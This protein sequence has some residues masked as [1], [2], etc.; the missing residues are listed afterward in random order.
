MIG[1]TLSHYKVLSK[2]GAGG[3]GDV[4]LAEDTELGRKVALKVLPEAMANSPERLERFRR[5]ARAVAALDHPNIVRIHNFEEAAGLKLLVMELVD[6]ESLDRI[7][8]PGGMPLAKVFSIAVPMADALAAAHEKGIT[9]RD[10]KPANVMLTAGGTVKVLDFG[11]AK[12][13]TEETAA[14]EEDDETALA[15][16][17]ADL[18][19]EGVVMGTAPYMSPEQLQGKPVD[20]RTDIFSLGIVLY[21]MVTG[22]R[23][24]KGESGIDL[25]SRILRETPSS[26]TDIRA[27]LPRHLGR[28][29]QH[30]L[31]KDPERRYQSAKDVRNELEALKGEIESGPVAT[32]SQPVM[33]AAGSPEEMSA[34]RGPSGTT[35]APVP[36]SGPATAASD[37]G[38][39][40]PS[41]T[42]PAAS[43][44]RVGLWAGVAAAVIVM[45]AGAWWIG[46]RGQSTGQSGGTSTASAGG[47][48]VAS[49]A[50]SVA[51]LPFADLSPDKDQEYFTDGMT[52]ELLQAL[53]TIEGLQV[54]SRTAIF[55][56]KG[57]ELD[58]QQVGERLNVATV[59]EGSVRKAGTRLRIST[60]LVQVADGFK[61]WSETYDR[62]L[63]DVFTV[64]DE[65]AQSIASAL[66]LTFSSE[67]QSTAELGGTTDTAAYDFYLRGKEYNRKSQYEY[68]L[69][70]YQQAV[71][72]DPAYALAY[73]GL[74]AA[75]A[76]K[77]EFSGADPEDLARAGEA[78]TRA[79]TLAPQLAEAHSSLASFHELSGETDA[80]RRE[81]EEALRLD[82]ENAESYWRYGRF[83]Y[84]LG[85]LETAADLWE[86]AVE[87][88]AE[89]GA[90]QLLPQVYISLGRHDE[91][92]AS[93]RRS[94]ELERRNL[95]LNPDD[96]NSRLFG[97]TALFALGEEEQARDWAQTALSTAGN[98]ALALYNGACFYSKAGDVERALDTLEQSIDAG[99]GIL[100]ALENDS[101]L[102][103]IRDHP[104][105]EELQVR[106]ETNG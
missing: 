10:L 55:A 9:H 2:L 90:T 17:T 51:V 62:E 30:C 96:T 53:G 13:A 74:A 15:T 49:S 18:T 105:F 11:L 67:T 23:P 98:D 57:K 84:G 38:A 100:S 91:A 54:P 47:A 76:N 106:L 56:L 5:E 103:N 27:D 41:S 97:A 24:F 81:H 87:F 101:D 92:L 80:A 68:S 70:M 94:L 12:L 58:I 35:V 48:M 83:L 42:Q 14:P 1:Q 33:P 78:S 64:Q 88:D 75:F 40:V 21:E 59:L 82:P 4:Y 60:Q 45:A 7:I 52:E 99:F 19:G 104:R 50:P 3:M 22:D 86:R 34:A 79:L 85:E 65:I 73:T 69:Q 66:R 31:E 93:Y 20:T 102:D 32:G 28:I 77:Y 61:L 43:G 29:I 63:E 72:I 37:P 71:A 46:S 16:A 89:H 44:S 26:V 8:P 25:A 36:A 39:A 6:G 95:E